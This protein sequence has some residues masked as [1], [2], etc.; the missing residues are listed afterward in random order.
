MFTNIY[1]AAGRVS[2]ALGGP[3]TPYVSS[4]NH[5]PSGAPN[6]FTFGN[7][8]ARAYT[9]NNRLQPTAIADTLSGNTMFS[10]GYTF[11]AATQITEP[12]RR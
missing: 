11:G 7:N 2:G 5:A 9:Y 10:L 4:L 1:D 6:G 3:A 12:Q 8:V